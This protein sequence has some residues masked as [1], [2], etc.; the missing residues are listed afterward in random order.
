MKQLTSEEYKGRLLGVMLKID[1]ICRENDIWYSIIYGTLLGAVRHQ[2]FIPWDDDIDIAMPRDA[3]SKLRMHICA[4]PELGLNCIDISNHK[5]T[6]YICG[7]ICDA[8]TKVIES[9]FRSVDGYGAF[10]DVFLLDNIPDDEKERKRFKYRARCMAKLVQHSA[11]MR[12]GSPQGL[13]HAV[14]LYSAF[15]VGHCFSTYKLIKKLDEYCMRYNDTDTKYC[16][17]PYFIA[18][19]DKTDFNELIDLPFEGHMLK[20]PKNYDHVLTVTYENYMELP[21]PEERIDH[22]VECSWRE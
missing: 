13:R 9:D 2:G 8:K 4:H 3:Y 14:L 19:F 21:P 11:K 22:M 10:V 18:F 15:V 12:P 17:V 16:G 6:I 7:K 20:G 1:T 5:D